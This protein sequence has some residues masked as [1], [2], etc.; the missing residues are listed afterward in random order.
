MS[1]MMQLKNCSRPKQRQ[2]THNRATARNRLIN[3]YQS[4]R[5][6]LWITSEVYISNNMLSTECSTWNIRALPVKL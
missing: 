6:G 4:S 3:S 2:R 1:F 5:G